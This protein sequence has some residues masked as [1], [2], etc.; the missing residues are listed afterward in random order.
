[1][2]RSKKKTLAPRSKVLVFAVATPWIAGG[3]GLNALL[4]PQHLDFIVPVAALLAAGTVTALC[5]VVPW[6]ARDVADWLS[7]GDDPRVMTVFAWLSLVVCAGLTIMVAY[8]WMNEEQEQAQLTAAPA[9]APVLPVPEVSPAEP[10]H[11]AS[12]PAPSSEPEPTP[13]PDPIDPSVALRELEKLVQDGRGMEPL[14]GSQDPELI[15]ECAAT[16]HAL[17]PWATQWR[18]DL[19]A[20]EVPGSLHLVAAAIQV[21]NCLSC[22]PNATEYCD[23]AEAELR[24]A[25]KHIR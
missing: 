13:E 5:L 25:R 4:G 16:M 1:M 10:V 24:D 15:R 14:R 11:E 12:P 7:A 20:L 23:L 3:V 19:E 22:L 17:Q 9:R 2:G 8:N 21:R 18:E 6:F